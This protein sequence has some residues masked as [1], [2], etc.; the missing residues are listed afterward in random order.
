MNKCI[1]QIILVFYIFY[2]TF[3]N[4][5]ISKDNILDFEAFKQSAAK[6]RQNGLDVLYVPVVMYYPVYVGENPE[7]FRQEHE[8]EA[9]KTNSQSNVVY[10]NDYII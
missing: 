2:A 7:Q 8:Q 9:A 5:Q 6:A 10:I 3:K 4:M 1:I